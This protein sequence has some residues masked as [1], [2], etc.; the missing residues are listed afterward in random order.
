MNGDR[1]SREET[2]SEYDKAYLIELLLDTQDVLLRV[3]RDAGD[4][5]AYCLNEL[6]L[7]KMEYAVIRNKVEKGIHLSL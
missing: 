7:I 6:R 4:R 5:L 3:E 1:Q 2:Y